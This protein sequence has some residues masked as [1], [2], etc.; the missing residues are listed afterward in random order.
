MDKK[1]V[2]IFGLIV[3]LVLTT[4]VALYLYFRTHPKH[5]DNS[6]LEEQILELEKDN[7]DLEYTISLRNRK[8]ERRDMEIDSLLSLKPQI[9]IKYVTIYK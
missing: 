9:T 2:I 1:T 8:M 3:L 6:F 5:I 7:S 4:S